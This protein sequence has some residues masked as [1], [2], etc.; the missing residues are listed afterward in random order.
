MDFFFFHLE[1][2]FSANFLPGAAAPLALPPNPNSAKPLDPRRVLNPAPNS[3]QETNLW[4]N[5]NGCDEVV[6]LP[7]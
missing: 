4:A 2:Q 3:S 7:Y 5:K 1:Y 6:N